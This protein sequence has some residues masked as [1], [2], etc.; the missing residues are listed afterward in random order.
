MAAAHTAF[1]RSNSAD[2][3]G[4]PYGARPSTNPTDNDDSPHMEPTACG[5]RRTGFAIQ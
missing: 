5:V 4:P 1:Y 3:D 2:N